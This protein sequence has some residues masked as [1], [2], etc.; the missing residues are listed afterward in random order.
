MYALN[1]GKDACE[2]VAPSSARWSTD[3]PGDGELIEQVVLR[4]F[5]LPVRSLLSPRRG[6][7]NIAFARQVAIYIAHVHLG[8]TLT[9]AASLFGRD[10]TTAAYACR[11]VEDRRDQRLIDRKIESIEQALSRCCVV[12][13]RDIRARRRGE[14]Q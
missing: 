9:R 6:R 7:A 12:A 13:A 14:L 3:L 2:D 8:M 10:R 5:E 1:S 4:T 11:I